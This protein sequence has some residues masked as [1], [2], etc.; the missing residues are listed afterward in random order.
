MSRTPRHP[1][2]TGT[3]VTSL[4]T[5]ACRVL[6]MF[7]DMATAS[8]L[9]LAGTGVADAFLFAFRIPNL[10]RSL[11]G[12]GALTASYLPVL[13]IQLENDPRVARQLSSVVVTLL[14]VLLAGLVAA[15]ELLF[16]LIWLIW[17]DVPGMGLLMGLSAVMLPYLLLI[18]I[19]AK[20][21]KL[22]AML[23]PICITPCRAA[24]Q[25]KSKRKPSRWSAGSCTATCATPEISTA[26][27][28]K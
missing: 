2:I 4:G 19:M 7:R 21:T 20:L 25:L 3:L 16:G 6:G 11:F 17:G 5:Q 23:R 28:N 15:G 24:G 1:L 22:G 10:F 9:G 26:T 8:L 27:A 14:A 18:C 13:T 12:E